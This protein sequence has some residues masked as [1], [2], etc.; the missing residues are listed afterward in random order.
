MRHLRIRSAHGPGAVRQTRC[1]SR[2]RMVGHR[3]RSARRLRLDPGR[4]GGGE[5]VSGVWCLPAV[6]T[7]PP[8]GVSE[9]C[10]GRL[11]RIPRCLLP[12]QDGGGRRLDPHSRFAADQ[13]G[14]TCRAHGH[15]PARVA[16]GRRR[17]GRSGT[18]HRSR[19]G[20]PPA[21]RRAAF[22]G[23][24]GH[25]RERA[26]GCPAPAGPRRRGRPGRATGHAGATTG[27]PSSR[28]AL[29]GGVRMLGAGRARQ[30][31]DSGSSTMRARSSSSGPVSNHPGSIR[32]A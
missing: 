21:R 26:I 12:V 30:K 14:R 7:W 31:R 11:R 2:P 16:V 1:H 24:L 27:D 32:T 8:F 6:S 9:P 19:P 3:G 13:G 23:D 5:P 15:H 22:P 28:R 10:H 18:G 4:P 29:H 25:H 20:R 17:P